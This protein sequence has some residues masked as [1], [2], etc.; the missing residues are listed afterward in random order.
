[1]AIIIA[2][3]YVARCSAGRGA[4]HSRRRSEECH[5]LRDE[6]DF[7]I[8]S[9]KDECERNRDRRTFRNRAAIPSERV[10]RGAL[11]GMLQ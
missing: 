9:L 10:T 8:P 5:G 2:A 11:L 4:R 7:S 6:H 1:M 3:Q